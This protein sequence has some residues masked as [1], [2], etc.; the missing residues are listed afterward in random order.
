M[1]IALLVE[2]GLYFDDADNLLTQ[3]RRSDE[4]L[5]G[6]NTEARR[7]PCERPPRSW[8]LFSYHAL[9]K[10][11]AAPTRSR[12]DWPLPVT[13][14]PCAFGSA[15]DD[16]A[17]T[18]SIDSPVNRKPADGSAGSN[19]CQNEPAGGSGDHRGAV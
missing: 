4:G 12:P 9:R 19:H 16:E 7:P 15:V 2:A 5:D 13:R 8:H 18:A 3:F 6:R 1:Q 10:S 17:E 14:L 11:H